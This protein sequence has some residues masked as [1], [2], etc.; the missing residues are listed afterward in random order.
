MSPKKGQKNKR[1]LTAKRTEL[2]KYLV[3]GH[4]FI[5]IAA[6]MNIGPPAVTLAVQRL[7]PNVLCRIIAQRN[8]NLQGLVRQQPSVP[9]DLGDELVAIRES[10]TEIKTKIDA[11]AEKKL[12]PHNRFRLLLMVADRQL[13]W[14]DSLLVTNTEMMKLAGFLTWQ[15]E[16]LATLQEASPEM[17]EAFLAKVRARGALASMT[18]VPA[19]ARAVARQTVDQGAGAAGA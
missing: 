8:Q 2:I 19:S 11:T 16:L 6:L 9:I 7:P 18:S 13:K 10:I 3:A 17:R 1:P 5:E 12:S 15:E 4:A 14:I